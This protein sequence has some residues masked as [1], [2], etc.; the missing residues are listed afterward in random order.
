MN[1]RDRDD[2]A[3]LV[4]ESDSNSSH[5]LELPEELPPRKSSSAQTHAKY[6]TFGLLLITLIGGLL[7][8]TPFTTQS[9]ERTP[10]VDAAFTSISAA[11]ITGL[12]TVDSA[13]HWND[14]GHVIILILIQTGGLG[15][16][17]G[18]GVLLL[19]L[20]RGA[21]SV[22]DARLMQDGAPATTLQEAL[23]LAR[24]IAIFTIIAEAIGAVIL[25]LEFRGSMPFGQAVWFGVFH[26]ISAFCNAGFEILPADRDVSSYRL[27][28]PFMV[29]MIV[30][31]QGG[32]L[33]YMVLSDAVK[34]RKWHRLALDT[35][36]VLIGWV[37][38]LL[39]A[40]TTFLL[41]EWNGLLANDSVAGK[42]LEATFQAAAGR[43]AGFA[44][45]DWT[46]ANPLTLLFWIA[47]MMVG[48]APG[49]ATGG[50]K[51]TTVVVIVA[52]MLSAFRARN[53][54]E[55][56][57]RR[58]PSAVVY[59]ALAIIGFFLA[60]HFTFTAALILLE[61]GSKETATETIFLTFEAM[62][63]LAT[64]GLSPGVTAALT[65][66]GK[67]LLCLAMFIGRLGPIT[68]AYA[69]QS[70]ATDPVRTLPDGQIRIG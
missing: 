60:M 31:I 48:G 28:V 54:V 30:L 13:T 22:R 16:M 2:I 39:G 57:N 17:V 65:D 27:S 32:A 34:T 69:L 15:F 63:A 9:G 21:I 25:T 55:I 20:R 45:V 64:V 11:S 33:S 3:V 24:Q 40:G 44:T 38:M 58:I 42:F 53:E 56:G 43:T 8:A 46:D 5:S 19:I 7:L 50:V 4:Q 12:I 1:P 67:I 37:V 61:S 35:R 68:V 29:T 10:V 51:I 23:M 18:A 52:A 70:R 66:G 14:L 49:S 6:F 59:R 47:A 62:S 41:I 26:S 36:I